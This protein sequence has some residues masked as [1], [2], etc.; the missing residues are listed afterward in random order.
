[1]FSLLV[2]LVMPS[3]T[4][5]YAMQEKKRRKKKNHKKPPNLGKWEIEIRGCMNVWGREF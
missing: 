4:D 3:K 2:L 1:M 5:F